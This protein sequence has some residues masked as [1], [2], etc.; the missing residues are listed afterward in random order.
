MQQQIYID[1]NVGKGDL[2]KVY[3]R[4]GGNAITFSDFQGDGR[5][6]WASQDMEFAPTIIKQA[7]ANDILYD[8][9]YSLGVFDGGEPSKTLFGGRKVYIKQDASPYAEHVSGV[10]GIDFRIA[11]WEQAEIWYMDAEYAW[12]GNQHPMRFRYMVVEGCTVSGI[13]KTV[14]QFMTALKA[15]CK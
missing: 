14:A 4:E 3:H 7:A 13:T 15:A 1:R 10:L 2:V 9:L 11:W 5:V 6:T 12:K 8:V